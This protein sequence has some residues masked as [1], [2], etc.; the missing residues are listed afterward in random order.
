MSCRPDLPVGTHV[1]VH[2]HVD[3]RRLVGRLDRIVPSD[4]VVGFNTLVSAVATI[5]ATTSFIS[6]RRGITSGGERPGLLL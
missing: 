1:H 4:E 2:V 3:L 5:D 6:R